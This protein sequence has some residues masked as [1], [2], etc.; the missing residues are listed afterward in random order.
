VEIE[1]KNYIANPKP[2]YLTEKDL[3]ITENPVSIEKMLKKV[4]LWNSNGELS[5]E[6]TK[7]FFTFAKIVLDVRRFKRDTEG[8]EELEA[9]VLELERE[10]NKQNDI[11]PFEKKRFDFSVNDDED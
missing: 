5:D 6:K 7:N 1:N 9:K 10:Q 3:K 11:I 8:I 2:R 4:I